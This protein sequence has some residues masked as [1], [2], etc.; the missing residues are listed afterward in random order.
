MCS[1][2]EIGLKSAFSL[3]MLK[4]KIFWLKIERVSPFIIL[5]VLGLTV[6]NVLLSVFLA[7]LFLARANS[8]PK[9]SV[10]LASEG[11]SIT[12]PLVSQVLTGQTPITLSYLDGSQFS[13]VKFFV[14]DTVGLE[15]APIGSNEITFSLDTV[16]FPDGNHTLSFEAIT[17]QGEISKDE[18]GVIF[19]ND[20]EASR[21]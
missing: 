1:N 8:Q 7:G 4:N 17:H 11:I 16:E 19:T 3:Q 13:Q 9:Y 6:L 15:L 5:A 21:E 2:L 10:S 20:Q 14:D 18:V 12:Q